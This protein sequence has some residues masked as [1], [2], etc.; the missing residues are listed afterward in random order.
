MKRLVCAVLT[1]SMALVFSACSPVEDVSSVNDEAIESVIAPQVFYAGGTVTV[2]DFKANNV[3]DLVWD[4][5]VH[6]AGDQKDVLAVFATLSDDGVIKNLAIYGDGVVMELETKFLLLPRDER[7]ILG[8]GIDDS[9][10]VVAHLNSNNKYSLT[11]TGKQHTAYIVNNVEDAWVA[12]NIVYWMVDNKVYSY[13]W[14]DEKEF[15]SELLC[16]EAYAVAHYS[17]EAQGAIVASEKANYPA[18]GEHNIFSPY[19]TTD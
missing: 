9:Y 14:I 16:D 4:D 1:L 17:D 2:G 5:P 19:G 12:E 7:F 15:I 8:C 3:V 18:R 11:I 6:L 13:K 10:Y